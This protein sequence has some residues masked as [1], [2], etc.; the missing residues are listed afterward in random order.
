MKAKIALALMHHK[1]AIDERFARDHMPVIQSMLSGVPLEFEQSIAPLKIIAQNG[2]ITDVPAFNNAPQRSIAVIP[3][4]GALMKN[5]QECGPMGMETIGAI[6]RKADT[7]ENISGIIL[8]ID[9]PGGTIDGTDTLANIVKNTKKPVIAHVEGMM[10]SAALWIGSNATHV[11]ATKR[12]DVGCI[13]VILSLMDVKPM[14]EQQGVAF[15]TIVSSQTPDK[16]KDIDDI[17]AGKYDDYRKEVL[18]PLAEDF[19]NAMKMSRPKM[20]ADQMTGKTY[21]A[22]T[23]VGTIVDSIGTFDDAVAKMNEMISEQKSNNPTMNKQFAAINKA[24]GVEALESIDETVAL[25]ITQLEA[26]EAA[27][28][29][30]ATDNTEAIIAAVTAATTERDATIAS[31][32]TANETATAALQ[33]MTTERNALQSQ[34]EVL[35]QGAG[36]DPAATAEKTDLG[37]GKK[38]GPVVAADDDIVSA[39]QKVAEEYLK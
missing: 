26:I 29:A 17:L 1:W 4:Q 33:A 27:L 25:N 12:S 36:A 32:T 23:V 3:I 28:V 19:I 18:D 8:K 15:H 21:F 37:E 20:K 2:D 9:S 10:C 24:L 34:V 14:L 6:I 16:N 38:A 30:T 11:M 5:D 35:T 22:D 7:N 13:G 31:L 39:T